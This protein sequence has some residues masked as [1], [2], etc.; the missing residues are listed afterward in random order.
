[1]GSWEWLVRRNTIACSD[2]LYRIHGTDPHG[3]NIDG[4]AL[5]SAIIAMG[6][7]LRLEL[8]AEGV[9]TAAQAEFPVRQ[10]GYLHRGFLFSHPLPA[11][12][13]A[14]RSRVDAPTTLAA[15]AIMA[16]LGN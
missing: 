8:I 7:I 16:T 4:A 5:T 1:M 10:G 2:E 15:D 9:E 13:F 11:E 14:K 12:E 6:R 3:E